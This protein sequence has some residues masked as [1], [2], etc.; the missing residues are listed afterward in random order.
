MTGVQTCALPIYLG[1]S[2]VFQARQLEDVEPEVYESAIGYLE[3]GLLLSERLG[4][5]QSQAFCSSSLGIAKIALENAAGAIEYLVKG[6]QAA[7]F[8][9]DLYLQGLNLAYLAQAYYSL[10]ELEQAIFAGCLGMYTLEQ[11][12]AMEWRQSAGLLTIL[13]GQMGAE[14]FKQS[15]AKSR[16]NIIPAIGVDGYDYIP[17]L[18]E[19]YQQSN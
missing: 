13:R 11:I 10:N 14:A 6:W 16:S 17:E 1:Y 15:L 8:S 2:E 12:G 18:L 9:G 3:Q 7:Q 5:R 4:D 19:K